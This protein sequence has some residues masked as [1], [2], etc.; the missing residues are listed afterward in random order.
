LKHRFIDF[1]KVVLTRPEAD[2]E[3]TG[4]FTYLKLYFNEFA[5]IAFFDVQDAE[6]DV[7]WSFDILKHRFIDFTQVVF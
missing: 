3:F 1:T 5:K 7:A 2:Y 6:Y 4:P